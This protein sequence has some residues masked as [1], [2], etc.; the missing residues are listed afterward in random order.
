MYGSNTIKGDDK[1]INNEVILLIHDYDPYNRKPYPGDI[2]PGS[3]TERQGKKPLKKR[4]D[5]PEALRFIQD[6]SSL[7]VTTVYFRRPEGEE[8]KS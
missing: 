5:N 6:H 2:K 3:Y 1:M 4:K 7:A 8:D